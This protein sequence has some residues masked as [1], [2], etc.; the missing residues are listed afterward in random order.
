MPRLLCQGPLHLCLIPVGVDLLQHLR[1]IRKRAITGGRELLFLLIKGG[2]PALEFTLN[3]SQFLI[4]AALFFDRIRHGRGGC[5]FGL[6][7]RSSWRWNDLWSR[8]SNECVLW[9]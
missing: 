9:S 1:E 2:Q 4:P 7:L 3:S 5:H 8:L 6:R